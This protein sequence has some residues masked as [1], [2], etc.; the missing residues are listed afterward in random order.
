MYTFNVFSLLTLFASEV[1]LLLAIYGLARNPKAMANRLFFFVALSMAMWG[2]GEGMQ[3]ASVDPKTAFFWA[4]YI[5]GLGSA[6]HP[7]FLMHFW[8]E[9]SGQITKYKKRMPVFIL[10]IPSTYFLL[11]RFFYSNSLINGMTKEYW[12]YS[13]SGTPLYL[14][15]MLFIVA[16]IGAV[17]Y[18][19]F[20]YSSQTR[21]KLRK[22]AQNIGFGI[23]FSLSLGVLTQAS[24]PI[25]HLKIPELSVI[26]TLIFISFIAHAIYKYGLLTIT[27]GMAADR[28][29]ETIT[30]Y[31]I[32]ADRDR[33]IA[34][35]NS[36][37]LD[38]LGK[39]KEE[40][41]GNPS[42]A[43]SIKLGKLF[44]GL[45]NQGFVKNYEAEILSREGHP[46]P[47]SV[48]ASVMKDELGGRIGFVLVLRDISH[49]KELIKSLEKNK[50][51]LVEIN[52]KL[53]EASQ[54]KTEFVSDVSHELRTPLASIKGFVATIRYEKDMDPVTREDFLKII[55][56][57]SDRLT[58]IIE[59]LLDLSRIEAGRLKVNMIP[60]EIEDIIRKNI[61]GLKMQAQAR[62]INI[63]ESLPPQLPPVFADQDKT[64]QVIINLLSNAIK[65]NKEGGKVLVSA[66]EDGRNIRV[67]VEDTGMGISEND[68]PHMFEKFYRV[69]KSSRETPGTGL[70]LAVTKSLVEVMGGEI[71]VQSRPGE[72]SKFS[73]SLPKA[74]AR[75]KELIGERS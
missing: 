60:L 32:V 39:T 75:Q 27:P 38:M 34:L 45:E 18:L 20:R 68:L 58:R 22:Q 73:F 9:F 31:L 29:I 14:I 52:W 43:L 17:T 7:A 3:R 37:M 23:L 48:N 13:S 11:L 30:D 67:D 62:A 46:V 64:A 16:Y 8:L 1:Y 25:L 42:S 69:E 74:N 53:K 28:I 59:D 24:R 72:G 6:L 47:L 19:A 49:T 15:Y 10:Y 36:S 65:Y 57:E 40:L 21:G 51:E 12:G 41:I 35:A 54:K 2:L 71:N 44:E 61:E 5:I 26:S 66:C 4:N 70:G 50:E 56:E 33:N 63:E 55:E